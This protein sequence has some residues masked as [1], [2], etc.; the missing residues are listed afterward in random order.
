MRNIFSY[1]QLLRFFWHGIGNVDW[2]EPFFTRALSDGG[3]WC[4]YPNTSQVGGVAA[5]LP[6][7]RVVGGWRALCAGPTKAAGS[8][9]YLAV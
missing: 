2:L 1:L 5:A 9:L 8:S 3:G 4:R 6:L 7:Y